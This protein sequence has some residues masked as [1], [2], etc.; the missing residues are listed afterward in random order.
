MELVKGMGIM[1]KGPVLASVLAKSK[2]WPIRL[3]QF[4][5]VEL[6]TE[7]ELRCSTVC[8]QKGDLPGFDQDI[9][10]A[11]NIRRCYYVTLLHLRSKEK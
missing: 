4:L 5:M 2:R 11:I 9:I 10:Y 8:E 6:F 1:V 7:D 3:L